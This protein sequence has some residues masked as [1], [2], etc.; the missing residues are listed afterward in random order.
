[1]TVNGQI[2]LCFAGARNFWIS[3]LMHNY[4]N[5]GTTAYVFGTSANTM[6]ESKDEIAISGISYP[7]NDDD[8]L[9]Y[10][11][12]FRLQQKSHTKWCMPRNKQ[13]R[14]KNALRGI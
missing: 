4:R 2:V 10:A 12:E 7:M 9:S 14:T 8:R 6:Q 13:R 5:Q 3:F 11:V 1:M